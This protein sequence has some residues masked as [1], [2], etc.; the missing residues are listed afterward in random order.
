MPILRA[1]AVAACVAAP[2][3]PVVAQAD[4]KACAS[5]MDDPPIPARRVK[6]QRITADAPPVPEQIDGSFIDEAERQFAEE[7][8]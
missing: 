8:A 2:W 4:P 7:D 5:I 6:T 3:A 1:I